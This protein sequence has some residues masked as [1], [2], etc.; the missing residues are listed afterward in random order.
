MKIV[1]AEESNVNI[2]LKVND[3]DEAGNQINR[4][5]HTGL[6][7]SEIL[8]KHTSQKL[9]LDWLEAYLDFDDNGKLIAIE[10]HN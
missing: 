4:I 1:I 2:V 8:A 7:L 9:T 10:I 3:T 6:A 5:S